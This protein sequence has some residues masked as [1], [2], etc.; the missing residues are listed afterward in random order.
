MLPI[1]V[2]IGAW[3]PRL[4]VLPIATAGCQC[5]ERGAAVVLDASL[6]AREPKISISGAAC[7]SSGVVCQHRDDQDRCDVFWIEPEREGVCQLTA[8]FADGTA[9]VE[10]IDFDR[11]DEYPC[12]GNVRPR[13]DGIGHLGGG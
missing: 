2:A 10:T 1:V 8:S 9:E 7:P 6:V 11:D 12:R 5:S 4:V 13:H 3:L